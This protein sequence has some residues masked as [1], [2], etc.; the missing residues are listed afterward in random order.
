T[1]GEEGKKFRERWEVYRRHLRE[2]TASGGPLRVR[3][4]VI[5]PLNGLLGYD[6][7]EDTDDVQTREG[8]EPGG[9]L[10]ISGDGQS[11]LRTW[12]APFNEDLDAPSRRG[13]AYRFSHLRIAQRVLLACGE[14]LGLLTNGVE[15]RLLISDL[16]RPDSQVIIPIDPG[17]KRSRDIP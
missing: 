11:R 9:S 5:E 16:A 3:N 8:K 6:K 14:R 10:L 13:R 17:W 12:T 7:P 4:K 15:V 1:T 2:L